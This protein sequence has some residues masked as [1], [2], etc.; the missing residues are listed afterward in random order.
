VLKAKGESPQCFR[1]A[2]HLYRDV[3]P[4]FSGLFEAVN[5]MCFFSL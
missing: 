2:K 1:G 3:F 5:N 4:V